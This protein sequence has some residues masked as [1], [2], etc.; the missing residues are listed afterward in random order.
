MNIKL[1]VILSFTYLYC[2]CDKTF[3][4]PPF[5]VLFF[6]GQI[7]AIKQANALIN[8]VTEDPD[9]DVSQLLPKTA[10]LLTSGSWEKSNT[11]SVVS[12]CLIIICIYLHNR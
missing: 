2:L 9:A 1:F 11:V 10:K 4:Y 8:A 12:F 6:R 5:S 7:E 3:Y